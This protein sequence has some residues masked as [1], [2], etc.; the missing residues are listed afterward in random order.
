MAQHKPYPDEEDDFIPVH[1][2]KQFLNG[3]L[4][5]TL[6]HLLD[7]ELDLSLLEARFRNGDSDASAYDP[8]ILLKIVRAAYERG[9]TSSRKIARACSE[10]DTLVSL[11]CRG[12]AGSMS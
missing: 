5:H 8:R 1:F 10:N 2:E 3:T 9:I 12:H 4:E 6:N 7:H 11:L